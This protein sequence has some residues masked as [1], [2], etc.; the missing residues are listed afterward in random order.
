MIQGP[1]AQGQEIRTERLRLVPF[2]EEFLTP[3]Y[4]DWL[5]DPQVVRFSRQRHS[6]HTLES[7]RRY[8]QS[9][10]GT[11]N[12]L[13]AIVE[14]AEGLGHIGNLSASIDPRDEVADLG[15][16]IGERGAWG[17]GYG[18]EAWK[19]VCRHLFEGQGVRKITAGTYATNLAMLGIMR[20]AG[21]ADDGRR[22]RHALVDGG[23]V[24][25][26]HAAL[27]REGRD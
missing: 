17:R 27:F 21:M 12:R 20:A 22:R 1:Q 24:D 13:W 4:V 9:F 19:A 11:P 26:I 23:A 10:H 3:R 8:W 2:G 18:A 5:N 25:V 16:L 6:V 14:A 7:C 15:I